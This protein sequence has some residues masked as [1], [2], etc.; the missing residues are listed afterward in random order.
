M[1][2]KLTKKQRK[3]VSDLGRASRALIKH[4]DSMSFWVDED[5]A[6]KF[7]RLRPWLDH[8]DKQSKYILR[9]SRKK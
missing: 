9:R 3:S 1:E 8:F 4:Y 7:E 2:L 6:N 5:L